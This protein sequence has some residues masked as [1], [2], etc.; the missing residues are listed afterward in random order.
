MRL[1]T[2]KSS[3]IQLQWA[4][5]RSTLSKARE[6]SQSHLLKQLMLNQE[7]RKPNIKKLLQPTANKKRKPSNTPL[8]LHNLTLQKNSMLTPSLLLMLKG[9]SSS[10]T[11]K[12]RLWLATLVSSRV[13]YLRWLESMRNSRRKMLWRPKWRRKWH[14][15]H[16]WWQRKRRKCQLILNRRSRNLPKCWNS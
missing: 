10:K 8:E 9:S 5:S 14:K 11:S 4:L 15:K 2:L 1:T 12:S 13:K 7:L 6:R 3:L 16:K